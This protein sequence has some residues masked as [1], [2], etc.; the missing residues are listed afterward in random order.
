M[1]L[2][3]PCWYLQGNLNIARWL[4]G[5]LSGDPYSGVQQHW[6]EVNGDSDLT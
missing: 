1:A 6:I 2:F 3:R 5:M 4:A